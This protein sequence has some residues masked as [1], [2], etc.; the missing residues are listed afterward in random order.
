MGGDQAYANACN[1]IASCNGPCPCM[2]CTVSK[3]DMCELDLVKV[4]KYPKR[5]R[6]QSALLAHAVLGH[7][8]AC[9]REIVKVVSDP[10]TQVPLARPGDKQPK[11][12]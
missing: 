9:E 1:A 11:V 2:Y 12:D 8:P 5:T 3:Y 6:N 10:K 4:K 7:C